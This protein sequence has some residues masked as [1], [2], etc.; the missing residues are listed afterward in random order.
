MYRI[1]KVVW[2]VV[3]LALLISSIS[4]GASAEPKQSA[5]VP[6][7]LSS[8]TFHQFPGLPRVAISA[9]GNLVRFEG[10]LGYDHIGVGAFSEGYVLCYGPSRAYDTGSS[11]AGFNA[12]TQSCS[13]NTCTVT[14]NTTD[15][16]MQ[17][18]QVITFD[19]GNRTVSFAMTLK[20]L[21]KGTITGVVLRRQADLD[22]DT[23]GASGTGDFNNPDHP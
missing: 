16:K 11:E 5:G 2:K 7:P 3:P 9:H 20:N 22:V 14:R 15:Q 10:P 18:K 6:G 21:T 19:K 12:G 4:L 8:T 23:G 17:L 1:A 13:S